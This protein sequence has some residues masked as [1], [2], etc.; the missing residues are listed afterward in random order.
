MSPIS[1]H[2]MLKLFFFRGKRKGHR[3]LDACN[4]GN[5]V[6]VLQV[7]DNVRRIALELVRVWFGLFWFD[8]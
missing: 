2:V 1:E 8:L 5:V 6:A 7:G 3:T 4:P